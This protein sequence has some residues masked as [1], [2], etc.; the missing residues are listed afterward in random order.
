MNGLG[1]R[2]Y[3]PRRAACDDDETIGR[4]GHRHVEQ[5]PLLGAAR[6]GRRRLVRNEARFDTGE[7]P[8]CATRDPSRRGRSAP[9]RR[10]AMPS[11]NGLVVATQARNA[12]SVTE[13]GFA[14]EVEHGVATRR[15]ARVRLDDAEVGACR[16]RF[17]RVL[18]ARRV[19]GVVRPGPQLGRRS[20]CGDLADHG[21]Q[22]RAVRG[23]AAADRDARRP[24]AHRRSGRSGRSCA[25]ARRSRP[26][27]RAWGRPWRRA[28]AMR[29][30]S[31][32]SSV[33]ARSAR[34][35]RR[36]RRGSTRA[37]SAARSRRARAGRPATI[38]GVQRWFIGRRMISMPGKRVSTSTSRVGIGTVEP[39]D[40]L[41]R[42]A[43]E[44]QV[45][46]SGAEDVDEPVLERV[47]V[48]GF[49]DE[50]VAEAPAERVGEVAV[51]YSSSRIVCAST[52]SKSMMPRRRLSCLVARDTR[53]R[54]SRRRGRVGVAIAGRPTRTGSAPM[55][56]A[57]AQLISRED[58]ASRL[59]RAGASIDLADE[60]TPVGDDGLRAAVGV[61]PALL[62][63]AEHHRVERARL[64]VVADP[65]AV[66]SPAQF[67]G[68]LSGE[69][70]HERVPGYRP[71]R[72]RCG[73][74]R[75]A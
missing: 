10:R 41:R 54:T 39:V 19:E 37:S 22:R 7:R 42:I 3:P 70:E 38:C 51:A 52:S 72:S 29:R 1:V 56:R 35:P 67:A 36:R 20:E 53:R 18:D 46:A 33:G 14:E 4:P 57:G 63:H 68:S 50:D 9:R 73:T 55:P 12:G 43:D 11:S 69:R 2:A 24:R 64:D 59:R 28:C 66:Q 25:P 40:R 58:S 27:A 8:R 75:G 61:G 32:A 31:S 47:E 15:R 16:G 49:V 48:L 34:R 13:R 23:L 45:V 65:R 62:E 44:E 30:A 5:P 17:A 74:R 6:G 26:C 60:S 71:T 21:L